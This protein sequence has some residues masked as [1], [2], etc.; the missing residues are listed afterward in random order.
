MIPDGTAVRYVGGITRF[1]G[2]E[3]NIRHRVVRPDE[4]Q[5]YYVVNLP[6]G[7][8]RQGPRPRARGLSGHGAG[9]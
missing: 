9:R 7:P 3:G 4:G 2:V 5:D 6:G 1:H 8:L